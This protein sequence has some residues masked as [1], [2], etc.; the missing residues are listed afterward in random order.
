L[1]RGAALARYDWLLFL[2]ADT[3]LEAGWDADAHAFMADAE[4]T[5]RAAIFR[6]ALDDDTQAARRL[7]R[8]VAWRVK[9]FGLAYGD[10]GLLLARAFYLSLGGFKPLPIMEDVDLIRRIGKGRLTQL[11]IRAVTSAERWRAEGWLQRSA[12]NVICLVCYFAG[13]PPGLIARLYAP[14]SKPKASVRG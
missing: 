7:E 14:G 5:G 8:I 12:R 11:K 2:H 6:F 10:Q 1:A 4:N 9:T 3:K 13:L